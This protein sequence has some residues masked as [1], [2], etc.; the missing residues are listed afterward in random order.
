MVVI[1]TRSFGT[2][3][4]QVQI[5]PLRPLFPAL[6]HH[7]TSSI[8]TRFGLHPPRVAER[9]RGRGTHFHLPLKGGGRL[10]EAQ[11]GGGYGLDIVSSAAICTRRCRTDPAPARC[12]RRPSPC[13]GG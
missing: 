8:E 3:G 6:A 4:S 1:S 12:A 7:N 11:S 13:R 10:R 5:L 2:R 9:G